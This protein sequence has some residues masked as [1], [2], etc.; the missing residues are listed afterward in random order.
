VTSRARAFLSVGAIGFVLQMSA[1]ALLTAAGWPYAPAAV[2]AVEMAVLNNFFWHE[3]WTWRDRALTSG[4]L[5]RLARFHLSAGLT[6]IVGSLAFTALLVEWAAAPVL[7]ANA[8][9]VAL[10]AAANY[11]IADRWVFARPAAAL[12]SVMLVAGATPA[13]AA[14]PQPETLSAWQAYVR[15]AEA[16]GNARIAVGEPAGETIAVPG[17]TIHRWRGATLVR[18]VTVDGL[19]DALMHPG[20][21]PPQED[22]LESRVLDRSG[23]TLRVYIKLVRSAVVTV[24]YDTEHTMTFRRESDQVTTSRSVATRIA[25]VGGGDR[26]FLWR[27]NSYWT[28]R[29]APEGVV[30]ELESLSLSRSVPGLIRP[31]AGPIINRI[32]RESMVRTLDALRRHV[33]AAGSGPRATGASARGPE[34]GA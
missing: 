29:Q 12:V 14:E 11:L 5:S 6:S 25:E 20:T 23:P 9:A 26:G 7:L 13:Q 24:T 2:V 32:A 1:L 4:A 31:I 17:G 27:L 33:E 30:V 34:P 3:R 19:V 16:R 28:Y 18:G 10:T 8:A 15:A 21:A 22:V